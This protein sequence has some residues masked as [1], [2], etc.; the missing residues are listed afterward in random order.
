MLINCSFTI[1]NTLFYFTTRLHFA[2]RIK[3]KQ[4]EKYDKQDHQGK[5]AFNAQTFLNNH[6]NMK[7]IVMCL[8]H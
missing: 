4:Y 8:F 6:F 5:A 7:N 1:V 3:S 2:R